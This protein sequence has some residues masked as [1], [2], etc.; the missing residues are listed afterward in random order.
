VGVRLKGNCVP[1]SMLRVPRL[2]TEE[3][4]VQVN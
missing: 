1:R 3:F 4:R 2:G